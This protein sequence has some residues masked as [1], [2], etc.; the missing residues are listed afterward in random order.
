MLQ[1]MLDDIL[2]TMDAHL[3][4][5]YGWFQDC[6]PDLMPSYVWR[7]L[8]SDME[9]PARRMDDLVEVYEPPLAQSMIVDRSRG[10][11]NAR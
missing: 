7:A 4:A 8:V 6:Q 10:G 9:R 11:M 1:R 5:Y 2:F 3:S